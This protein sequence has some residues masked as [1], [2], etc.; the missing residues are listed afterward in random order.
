MTENSGKMDDNNAPCILVVDDDQTTLASLH[1]VLLAQG[2]AVDVASNGEAAL[3]LFDKNTYDLIVLDVMMPGM[4][5]FEVCQQL[6][7]NPQNERLPI[8]M[9]TGLEDVQS[10]ADAFEAGATDFITKPVNWPLLGHRIRYALRTR[11]IAESLQSRT[12]QILEIQRIARIGSWELDLDSKQILLSDMAQEILG[13]PGRASVAFDEY[14]QAI[15]ENAAELFAHKVDEICRSESGSMLNMEYS[16]FDQKGREKF[17]AHSAKLVRRGNQVFLAGSIQDISDRKQDQQAIF[18]QMNYDELTRLPNARYFSHLLAERFVRAEED[19]ALFPLF[20]V[21][22]HQINRYVS[23]L[24]YECRDRLL[25]EIAERLRTMNSFDIILSRFSDHAF[26]ISC[27]GF[28][29][30]Q[31]VEIFIKAI[32]AELEQPYFLDEH[33]V[34]LKFNAGICV[35]PFQVG[36]IPDLLKQAEVALKQVAGDDSRQIQFYSTDMDQ[37]ARTYV[38]LEQDLRQA[39]ERDEI[40]VFYQP[41][42]DLASGQVVGME[43]LARWQHPSRGLISPLDFI[44]VAE[45]SGL[46]IPVG[47]HVLETAIRQTAQWNQQHGLRLR[48]GVNLSAKQLLSDNIVQLVQ[49]VLIDSGLNPGLLDLEITESTAIYDIQQ[50]IAILKALRD[51]GVRTSM[52]DFGTGYSSLANLGT[53]PLDVL[54]IDRAF[55]KDIGEQGEHGAFALAITSMAHALGMRV[56]AE[57]V[58]E[59]WQLKVLANYKVDQVQGFYLSRPVAASEFLDVVADI[60]QNRSA[61]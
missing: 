22:P 51:I 6:R 25:R 58:E 4:S 1:S 10:V 7:L 26:G 42:L 2:F 36:T 38:E 45:E 11:E 52:D 41:Q 61:A 28:T 48:V 37:K 31:Q 9:L 55:V 32:L 54:K 30:I 35:Y 50:S 33:A 16:L 15:A 23:S 19:E 34:N 57:G 47:A 17:I 18:F 59:A 53:L 29:T 44:P 12:A 5:G 8:M 3:A 40:Q 24:G 21:A 39:V 49:Q 13:V 46:I 14:C 27:N 60:Q 56:I 20:I 43:A